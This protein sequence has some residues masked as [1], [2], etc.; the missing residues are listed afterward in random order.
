[1]S[2]HPSPRT[3][4]TPRLPVTLTAVT[5]MPATLTTGPDDRPDRSDSPV[6]PPGPALSTDGHEPRTTCSA[7]TL[8][9]QRM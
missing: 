7:P 8:H 9:G 2:D 6:D 4:T 3:P 5:L 1:M